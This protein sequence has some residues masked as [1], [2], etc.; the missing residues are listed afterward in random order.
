MLD[1]LQCGDFHGAVGRQ[2]AGNQTDQ[3]LSLI[4]ISI[5]RRPALQACA[6]LSQNLSGRI[7]FTFLSHDEIESTRQLVQDGVIDFTIGQEPKD[8][9]YCSVQMMFDYYMSGKQVAPCN[10]ITNTVIKIRENIN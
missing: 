4:H 7:R 10:H 9:G 1:R 5:L 8:Q 2:N 3:G 6:V